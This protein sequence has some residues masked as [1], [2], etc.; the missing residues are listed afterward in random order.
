MGTPRL[1]ISAAGA[2][3]TIWVVAAGS[4]PTASGAGV[5]W[6][7]AGVVAPD[8]AADSRS[9][10]AGSG[11]GSGSAG[12]DRPSRSGSSIGDGGGLRSGRVTAAGGGTTGAA[13]DRSAGTEGGSAAMRC[14]RAG[15][16]LSAPEEDVSVVALASARARASRDLGCS[17]AERDVEPGP[18]TASGGAASTAG[19][20][21]G[22]RLHCADP[23]GPSDATTVGAAAGGAAVPRLHVFRGEAGAGCGGG[24]AA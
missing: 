18:A 4:E 14:S 1:E 23:A 24:D 20:D 15:S 10:I 13:V 11:G 7:R 22:E 21:F 5:A 8:S 12:T 3:Q 2:F 16:P 17:S 9:G 19:G 6:P